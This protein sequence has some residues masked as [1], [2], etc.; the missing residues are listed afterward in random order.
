MGKEN[1]DTCTHTHTHTKSIKLIH[2]AVHL[3][4]T[5]HFKSTKLQYNKIKKQKPRGGGKKPRMRLRKPI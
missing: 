4:P 5:K 3:K 1:G 2:F